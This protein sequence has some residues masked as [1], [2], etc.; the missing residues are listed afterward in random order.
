MRLT[1]NEIEKLIQWLNIKIVQQPILDD[2]DLT[3]L[4]KVLQSELVKIKNDQNYIKV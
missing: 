2:F 1:R 4:L 3:P